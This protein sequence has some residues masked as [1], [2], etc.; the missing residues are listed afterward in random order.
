METTVSPP[1][2]T[3]RTVRP[4]HGVDVYE[5]PAISAADLIRAALRYVH[6]VADGSYEKFMADTDEANRFATFCVSELA[7][8]SGTWCDPRQSFRALWMRFI[9]DPANARQ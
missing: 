8:E 1:T 7:D 4:D 3:M 6:V 9:A 2:Y 5:T